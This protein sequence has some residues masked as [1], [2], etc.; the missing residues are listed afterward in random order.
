MKTLLGKKKYSR[1]FNP[2]INLGI[3]IK[4][5]KK[6]YSNINKY[7]LLCSLGF[8]FCFPLSSLSVFAQEAPPDNPPTLKE[9]KDQEGY[10]V[11]LKDL[12]QKSRTKIEEVNS[13]LKE[14]AML[15]RNQEREEKAREYYNKAMRLFEENKLK[16]AQEYWDKAIKITEHPE[17]KNY[18]S[19]SVKKVKRQEEA[20]QKEEDRRLKRLEI[21]RGYSAAEVE[22]AYQ[23]AVA[24]FKQQKFLASKGEFEHVDE[25][26]P[27]H[28]ATRSYLML[29][30]QKIKDDQ[31]RLIDEKIREE[32]IA[33]R[34]E[35]EEWKD[36][37]A[38][39]EKQR[40]D[41]LQKQAEDVY[42]EALQFYKIHQFEEAKTKFKEVE[43]IV[44]DYKLTAK[45]LSVIDDDIR[46]ELKRKKIDL[47]RF[48]EQKQQDEVSSQKRKVEQEVKR[49]E[50]EEKS[51]S[52]KLL[53]EAGFI[54][55]SA[56]ALF[57]KKLYSQ[58]K[59][60]FLELEAL[61]PGFKSTRSYLAKLENLISR[62]EGAT[63]KAVVSQQSNKIP[64]RDQSVRSTGNVF[65]DETVQKAV[66]A[67][68]EGLNKDV[69]LKYNKALSY[70]QKKSF[71]EAKMM[72]IQV[73]AMSP[74]FKETS[75]YLA[76]IDDDISRSPS[77]KNSRPASQKKEKKSPAKVERKTKKVFDH[78]LDGAYQEAMELF[79]IKNYDGA[80]RKFN[81]VIEMS[82]NYKSSVSYMHRINKILEKEAEKESLRRPVEMAVE[83]TPDQK[84]EMSAA[85]KVVSLKVQE[86]H[87][88]ML[89][90][91]RFKEFQ[92]Q[93]ADQR[94]A[95]KKAMKEKDRREL[96]QYGK[97]KKQL[98]DE[99]LAKLKE[100]QEQEKLEKQK[101]LD[102]ARQKV[103]DALAEKKAKIEQARLA[104]QQAEDKREAELKEA[105]E[106]LEKMKQEEIDNADRAIKAAQAIK[107]QN[108]K[109]VKDAELAAIALKEQKEK[110]V[111]EIE[112]K[113]KTAVDVLPLEIPEENQAAIAS[114]DIA[115]GQ[116]SE[117][118]SEEGTINAY[119]RDRLKI[120]MANL[121]AE[122]NM[123]KIKQQERFQTRQQRRDFRKYQK[124]I[125]KRI[126]VKSKKDRSK[127]GSQVDNLY[128]DAF[129]LFAAKNYS[130]AKAKF[131]MVE[132]ISP[133]YGYCRFYI[134]KITDIEQSEKRV[135]QQQ[136]EERV[137]ME[138]AEKER[139]EAEAQ[140][141]ALLEKEKLEKQQKID[142]KRKEIEEKEKV[143]QEKRKQIEEQKAAIE[144]KELEEKE[145]LAEQRRVAVEEKRKQIEEQ[146]AAAEKKQ[147]EE[148]KK[149]AEQ[150]RVADEEKRKKDEEQK[151]AA[152]KIKNAER[153]KLAEQKR[154]AVEEKKKLDEQKKQEKAAKPNTKAPESVP[155]EAASSAEASLSKN[156]ENLP[157]DQ[158]LESAGQPVVAALSTVMKEPVSEKDK[159]EW[160]KEVAL[161]E[162]TELDSK[163]QL[164]EA[165]YQA[166]VA[167]YD[168]KQFDKAKEKF[169]DLEKTLPDY[170]K[171][172]WYL[173]SIDKRA[174][175]KADRAKRIEEYQERMRKKDEK[176]LALLEARNKA[177][178][179]KNKG[180]EISSQKAVEPTIENSGTPAV[181]SGDLGVKKIQDEQ[182]K[183]L[184][185]KSDEEK[186]AQKAALKEQARLEKEK[187]QRERLKK[188][189]VTEKL[190]RDIESV[191]Q[192]ALGLYRQK[193]YDLSEEKFRKY[194]GMLSNSL[195]SDAYRQK[196]RQRMLTDRAQIQKEFGQERIANTDTALKRKEVAIRQDQFS[197]ELKKKELA[198]L[199]RKI[200]EGEE[201][202]K[203]QRV[204]ELKR[205]ENIRKKEE[206]LKHSKELEEQATR[207]RLSQSRKDARFE[208]NIKE[209]RNDPSDSDG[210]VK[211][212]KEDLDQKKRSLTDDEKKEELDR[213]VKSRQDELRKEREQIRAQFN[214]NLEKLYVK[215]VR[216]QEQ[217]SIPEAQKIFQEIEKMKP[218]Y[219]KTQQYLSSGENARLQS[220]AK[221]INKDKKAVVSVPRERV[222]ADALNS[223][224]EGM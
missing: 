132:G 139:L 170:K 22:S 195:V 190:K 84:R 178:N 6:F 192:E 67:H 151:A 193:Q 51:R 14:Q 200:R 196:M 16:E 98:S 214:D 174:K 85:D 115:S 68:D 160:K 168:T 3:N 135:L 39:R 194:E 223:L 10:V 75:E 179:Q 114:E 133:G 188:S 155:V 197:D 71:V 169:L 64:A 116:L 102:L 93:L 105:K 125:S 20:F 88:S 91:T 207:L 95:A 73:E 121:E 97:L 21:E 49:K 127:W 28:K 37:L 209:L 208:K 203:K 176:R 25:M 131:S 150:K 77:A 103:E 101:A 52:Q 109:L 34:K 118:T 210:N 137:R 162:K 41:Q 206:A 119:E 110:L 36:E 31:Q 89:E 216:L 44:P 106:R 24:L 40:S 86:E 171:S 47:K 83:L 215:A 117:S 202:L 212:M 142:A 48:E 126:S 50:T 213:L 30:E 78:S 43:W 54:Y 59:D 61:F 82:P 156:A 164:A 38:R 80:Y 18:V 76:R 159:Y 128:K 111:K 1:D 2:Q 146:K 53:D 19:E 66:S 143:A 108:I 112:E 147:L 90:K 27:D 183:Q 221:K 4:L 99:D 17:M 5:V 167:F 134:T 42:Q 144:K 205:L 148:K 149:L 157:N 180:K 187:L 60:K 8:L 222:I 81:E 74:G 70:Y 177:E 181:G 136:S 185:A 165:I 153:E 23:Q 46:N 186:K 35:K 45:Y 182:E 94:K 172:A 140:K 189:E 198:D 166:A 104:K 129:R 92:K 184:K 158:L 154:I 107:E 12:V 123:Q 122:K 29:I 79:K 152:E 87:M 72:F 11:N 191:Y 62:S 175:E 204:D 201:T 130:A 138:K 145:K 199:E 69:E 124:D 113:E 96:M 65:E 220:Q 217:G 57:K 161:K 26:F 55:E 32:A 15:R 7:L 63:K 9:K 211:K 173:T 224:E 33:R 218:G 141:N 56:E 219:K 13:K 120:A 100:K 163:K 58:S